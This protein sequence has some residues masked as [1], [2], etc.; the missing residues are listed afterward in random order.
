MRPTR[1]YS[2]W[3][4]RFPANPIQTGMLRFNRLPSSEIRSAFSDAADDF[5]KR[6]IKN[7][8]LKTAYSEC[9]E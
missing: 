9:L 6:M 1:A 2:M 5:R 8:R 7:D 3:I 4:N